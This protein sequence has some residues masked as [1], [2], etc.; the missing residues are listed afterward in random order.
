M[1]DAGKW[2]ELCPG[3]ATGKVFGMFELNELMPLARSLQAHGRPPDHVQSNSVRSSASGG[4]PRRPATMSNAGGARD[5]MTSFALPLCLDRP[6]TRGPICGS[7]E[8]TTARSTRA[9]R[10]CA[11]SGTSRAISAQSTTRDPRCVATMSRGR[12]ARSARS[13]DAQTMTFD[14]FSALCRMTAAC[15]VPWRPAS[16]PGWQPQKQRY[17]WSRR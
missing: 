6:M 14:E 10:S 9:A 15:V 3:N 8:K 16:R 13:R 2:N 7:T 1:A 5:A 11:R 4:L 12:L 17:A